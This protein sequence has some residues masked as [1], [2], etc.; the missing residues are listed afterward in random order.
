RKISFIA[1]A[2]FEN[3]P[4]IA[5]ADLVTELAGTGLERAFFV[6]GGSEAIES[7]IK[8]ARHYAVARG[9]I[10]RWKVIGRQPAYHG[11]TLGAL[12]AGGDANAEQIFGPMTRT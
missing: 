11:A 6:S 5:L 4:A 1:R 9:E 10:G 8:L 3:G 2:Q 12:A 7:A